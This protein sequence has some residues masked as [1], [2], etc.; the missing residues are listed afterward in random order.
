MLSGV[1]LLLSNTEGGSLPSESNYAAD[2]CQIEFQRK[3]SPPPRNGDQSCS[4]EGWATLSTCSASAAKATREPADSAAR[5]TAAPAP[6]FRASRR[7]SP[8]GCETFLSSICLVTDGPP[9]AKVAFRDS[10]KPQRP[11]A[12]R[13]RLLDARP[14]PNL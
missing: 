12:M 13:T 7:V 5:P 11:S 8:A 9:F 6:N 3:C 10:R 4:N 2:A 14:C 1:P